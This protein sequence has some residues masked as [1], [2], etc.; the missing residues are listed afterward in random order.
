MKPLYKFCSVWDGDPRNSFLLPSG[1]FMGVYECFIILFLITSSYKS[2][3]EKIRKQVRKST[4]FK[5]KM[6]NSNKFVHVW[7]CLGKPRVTSVFMGTFVV[8]PFTTLY[9]NLTKQWSS[10][11]NI[12]IWK[13]EQTGSVIR[14]IEDIRCN[15]FM[16][17]IF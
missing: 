7:A 14:L 13:L 8:S 6:K 17:K 3:Y 5:S 10:S 11:W 4:G 16:A 9:K 15:I 1:D 12:Q 2:I